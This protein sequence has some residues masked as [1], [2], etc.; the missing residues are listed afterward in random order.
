MMAYPDSS[1]FIMFPFLVFFYFYMINHSILN[2]VNNFIR[3]L[4]VVLF[5]YKVKGSLIVFRIQSILINN[6]KNIYKM[7]KNLKNKIK[8]LNNIIPIHHLCQ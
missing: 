8:V 1:S 7:K 5:L 4:V 2:D 3:F 6:H